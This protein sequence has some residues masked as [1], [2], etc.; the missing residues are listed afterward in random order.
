M[1][2]TRHRSL[3]NDDW[4]CDYCACPAC[5]NEDIQED[6]FADLTQLVES[7]TIVEQ[8]GGLVNAKSS[9]NRSRSALMTNTYFGAMLANVTNNCIRLEK[10]IADV[11]LC[12]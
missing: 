6:Q 10:A 7:Y 11:E 5:G 9:L 1:D 2:Y 8:H 4:T 12:Q 3:P